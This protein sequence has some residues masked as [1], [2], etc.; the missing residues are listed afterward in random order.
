MTIQEILKQERQIWWNQ[1]LSL[2]E[3]IVRIG[4]IF[5]DLCRI[6]RKSPKDKEKYENINE[7]KKELWNFISATI[8]WCNDLWFDPE[9]CIKISLKAQRKWVENKELV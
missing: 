3:I 1:K 6:A 7:L 2:H 5:G 8:R 4:V 9:E